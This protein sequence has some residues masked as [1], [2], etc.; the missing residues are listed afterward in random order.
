MTP[1]AQIQSSIAVFDTR[2]KLHEVLDCGPGITP[3]N[4]S[5]LRWDISMAMLTRLPSVLWQQ[6][7]MRG[8]VTTF[9][10]EVRLRT[11][12]EDKD[13]CGWPTTEGD[14]HSTVAK[15]PLLSATSMVAP[16]LMSIST[17]ACVAGSC[18]HIAWCSTYYLAVR[19]YAV[20]CRSCTCFY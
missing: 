4:F 3:R 13:D 20:Y 15:C 5:W 18:S 11:L 17:T 10:T 1:M 9:T 8:G 12:V 6:A 19:V 14:W 7:S 2:P 16:A